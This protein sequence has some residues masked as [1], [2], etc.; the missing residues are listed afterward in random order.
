MGTI[1]YLEAASQKKM[2]EESIII[3]EEKQL[4]NWVTD[5]QV[6]LSPCAQ[7][8]L[9]V[10]KAM[11]ANKVK[12]ALLMNERDLL[13]IAPFLFEITGPFQLSY[14]TMNKLLDIKGLKSSSTESLVRIVGSII[15]DS[16][17]SEK[18]VTRLVTKLWRQLSVDQIKEIQV[19][20][21]DQGQRLFDAST[22]LRVAEL[23][24]G[25]PTSFFEEM[26]EK[27][28]ELSEAF[29]EE[30]IRFFNKSLIDGVEP[31][32]IEGAK[33]E[34]EYKKKRSMLQDQTRAGKTH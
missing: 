28:K 16:R 7:K 11:A 30:N 24:L 31:S 14:E 17:L 13:E 18:A 26:V 22:Y 10:L 20:T 3:E 25:V 9:P 21:D 27:E 34:R 15:R 6:P 5:L 19:A 33:R 12:R 32:P 23:F 8:L 4:Y 1:C 29:Y 2:I